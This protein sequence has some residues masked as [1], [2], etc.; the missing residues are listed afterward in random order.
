M[1]VLGH[2]EAPARARVRPD[3]EPYDFQ[4][5]ATLARDQSRALE[6][7]FETF[8]RQWGTQLT[9]KIRV[10][11]RVALDQVVMQ[12]YDEYAASLPPTSAMILCT[13]DG[14]S[15]RAVV[16]FPTA[17]ALG[18][19]GRMLGGAG[20]I[21]PPERKFT[22]IEQAIVRA[23]VEDA[24]E[25]LEYSLGS[26]I[27][28]ALAVDTIHYNAQFAQAAATTEFMI[29]AQFVVQ[30]GDRSTAATVALPADSVLP[31]LGMT[32][33]ATQATDP[34]R[35]L[36]DQLAAA[37]VDVALQLD[38][39]AVSPAAILGLRVGDV[40]PLAHPQHRPLNIA[41]DGRTVAHAAVGANG[42]RLAC[43]VVDTLEV[44]A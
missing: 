22:P 20:S 36:R 26:L 30:V 2:L 10:I 18:W 38:A 42:A 13:L 7:A 4:R 9:A 31:Q 33:D 23:L 40:L 44:P 12:T 11:S 43:V 16:Q 41:V 24:L 14:A 6:F 1:T 5:P 8:A 15:A 34:A 39:T 28:S 35:A 27:T 21:E 25:D 29:V 17:A 37:P 19:V 32:P 3:A